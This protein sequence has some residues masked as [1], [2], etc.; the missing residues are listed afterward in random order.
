M[1]I[2]NVFANIWLMAIA[3]MTLAFFKS[4]CTG[5]DKKTSHLAGISDTPITTMQSAMK[6]S[7]QRYEMI[8][9]CILY[10]DLI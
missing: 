8:K 2:L 3:H 4:S 5:Q 10:Y 1:K 7:I 9:T 6:S